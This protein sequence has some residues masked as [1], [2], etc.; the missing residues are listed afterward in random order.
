MS[1]RTIY[2]R[3]AKSA[4]LENI[5]A[6]AADA[7][8]YAQWDNDRYVMSIADRRALYMSLINEI[9]EE[10][11][12]C[13]NVAYCIALYMRHDKNSPYYNPRRYARAMGIKK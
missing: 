4:A 10:Y 12:C 13:Y 9:R 11:K 1:S 7:G 8:K 5:K 6:I 2:S 3:A